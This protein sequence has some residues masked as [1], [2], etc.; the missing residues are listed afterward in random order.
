MKSLNLV[1][2]NFKIQVENQLDKKVKAVKSDHGG[3]H[4]DRYDGSGER[5]PR[6][7]AKFLEEYGI[8]PQYSMFDKPS[9]NG[10]TKRRHRTLKDMVRSMISHPSLPESLW[11]EA[12]KTAVYILNRV[13]SKV[14]SKTPYKLWTGKKPRIRH[15]YI[16]DCPSEARPY[17]PNEKKLD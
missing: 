9:M 8:V 10:V 13:P 5:C 2:K 4:Y 6:P 17:R 12:L 16:W 3:E 7:F 1:F 14:V 11:R 15:L